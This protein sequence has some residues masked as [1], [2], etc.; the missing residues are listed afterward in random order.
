MMVSTESKRLWSL[1]LK[2]EPPPHY[3]KGCQANAPKNH[4]SLVTSTTVDLRFDSL[5]ES[6]TQPKQTTH[7]L[8]EFTTMSLTNLLPNIDLATASLKELRAFCQENDITVQGDRRRKSSFVEAIDITRSVLLSD[9]R[10]AQY[11]EADELTAEEAQA[12]EDQLDEQ[13]EEDVDVYALLDSGL[14]PEQAFS[15][16]QLITAAEAQAFEDDLD[17]QINEHDA[18]SAEQV[19]AV[20]GT[21]DVEDISVDELDAEVVYEPIAP[22]EL[23]SIPVE[24]MVEELKPSFCSYQK[25]KEDIR[26]KFASF[27]EYIKYLVNFAINE[28]KPVVYA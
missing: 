11:A 17:E 25:V 8:Q 10:D 6:G 12:F 18:L 9:Y 15:S 27:W 3:P 2:A 1:L 20:I 23:D 7:S 16:D 28:V 14:D 13:L 26:P 4:S 19:L 21:E 24:P 5:I 22:V